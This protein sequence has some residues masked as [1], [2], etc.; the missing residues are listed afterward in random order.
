M[1]ESLTLSFLKFCWLNWWSFCTASWQ[2]SLHLLTSA[3]QLQ[4]QPSVQ[5]EETPLCTN[6]KRQTLQKQEKM[7]FNYAT[8]GANYF[9]T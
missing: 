7:L 3:L 5:L 1:S 2:Q 8:A 4:F 6:T 9:R